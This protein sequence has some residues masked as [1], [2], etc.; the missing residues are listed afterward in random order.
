MTLRE[1]RSSETSVLPE[2]LAS[3]LARED[4]VQPAIWAFNRKPRQGIIQLCHAYGVPCEPQPIAN[5]LHTVP[6]LLSQQI[7]EYLSVAENEAILAEF[8]LAMNLKFPFLVALR[9]ALSSSLHLPGEGEQI[10]RIVAVWARC[11]VERNP[12]SGVSGDQAYILAFATVLL[13][14]DLHNPGVPRR[15]TVQ[16]FVENVREA[17]SRDEMDDATLT[18]LYNSVKAEA[19]TFKRTEGDEFLALS[20]PR[21]KGKLCKKSSGMFSSWVEHYF[22]LANSCMYYFKTTRQLASDPPPDGMIQLVSVTVAPIGDDRIQLTSITS[23]LEYVKFPKKRPPQIMKGVK[24]MVFKAGSNP[25]REKWLYRMRTS[26]VY[27][28][29]SGGTE[30]DE[31]VH[32]EM[33]GQSS[34]DGLRA[35]KRSLSKMM[36]PAEAAQWAEEMAAEKARRGLSDAVDMSSSMSG[37]TSDPIPVSE[38]S[39]VPV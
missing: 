7:G 11:W 10:D 14:S 34:D 3:E 13:N 20:A 38:E 21:M 5:L 2:D 9:Q 28:H 4:E 25:E 39:S 23:E 15:M 22:V 1:S 36:P 29:F 33:P 30:D 6:G 35:R 37:L 17:I 18:D 8:F 16:Q 32:F 27:S 12:E 19:F 31:D 26:C 24:S